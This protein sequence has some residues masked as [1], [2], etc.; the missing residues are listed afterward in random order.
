MQIE[1]TALPGVMILTPARFGDDRGWFSEIWN[2][3]KM[4]AAG[5]AIDVTDAEQAREQIALGAA[6]EDLAEEY[7][8]GRQ[9]IL[10]EIERGLAERND[11]EMIGRLVAGRRRG[12]V[13]KD[14]IG[15]APEQRLQ[16]AGRRVVEK[17]KL[18]MIRPRNMRHG[19]AVDPDDARRP[20][21]RR[22]LQPAARRAAEIDDAR[23]PLQEREFLVEFLQLVGG[24]AAIALGLRAGDVRIVQLPVEPER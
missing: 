11:A 20:F 9:N 3:P 1:A 14:E 24:A 10:G 13:G 17:I 5:V 15:L 8:A 16:L 19:E 12:H 7:P 2:A 23:S 22:D 6:L 21:F 18:Q 4:A